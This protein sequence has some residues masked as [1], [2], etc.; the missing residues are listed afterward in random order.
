MKALAIVFSAAVFLSCRARSE[1]LLPTDAIGWNNY[2]EGTTKFRGKF[3]LTAGESTDNGTIRI[4]VVELLRAEFTGDAGDFAARPRVRIAFS[5]VSDG[6][7]MLS[8]VYPENGVGATHLPSEF[9]IFDVGV[10]SINLTDGWVYFV[11]TGDY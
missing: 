2:K 11:L 1:P 3:L 7:T 4:K 10:R 9:K 5:R 6:K 8:E